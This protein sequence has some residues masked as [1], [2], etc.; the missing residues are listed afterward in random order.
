MTEEQLRLLTPSLLNGRPNTYTLT[1][2]L[3]EN[4]LKE[5]GADLPISIIRPSII[6]ASVNEPMP[7]SILIDIYRFEVCMGHA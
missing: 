2:A 7:V 1:K 6:G 4:L 3:A 5:E